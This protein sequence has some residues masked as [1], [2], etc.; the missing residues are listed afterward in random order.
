[1]N[2]ASRIQAIAHRL[3]YRIQKGPGPAGLALARLTRAHPYHADLPVVIS[4]AE[5]AQAIDATPRLHLGCG[6]II[7][8]GYIN[9]GNLEIAAQSPDILHAI[10]I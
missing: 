5:L 7:A 3:G 6:Q 1:M 9:I 4:N 2:A 8:S 10:R